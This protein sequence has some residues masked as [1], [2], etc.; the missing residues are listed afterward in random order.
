MGMNV[1]VSSVPDHPGAVAPPLSEEPSGVSTRTTERPVIAPGHSYG[2]DH[3]LCPY[4]VNNPS[5]PDA[6]TAL[7]A[8]VMLFAL[9]LW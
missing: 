1:R 2:I 4:C 6:K 7:L 8:I 9:L 3:E 5:L